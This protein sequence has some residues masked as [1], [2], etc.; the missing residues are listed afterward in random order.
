MAT[1]ISVLESL[2]N[3]FSSREVRAPSVEVALLP[4]VGRLADS[5]ALEN[6]VGESD[7]IVETLAAAPYSVLN[8][9][10][11]S[12]SIL[13]LPE[14]QSPVIS[15]PIQSSSSA[16]QERAYD[17]RLDGGW[18]Q[19]ASATSAL[20]S[21]T[22]A[23]SV[24]SA[25]LQRSQ[26]AHQRSRNFGHLLTLLTDGRFVA[27]AAEQVQTLWLRCNGHAGL[28]GAQAGEDAALSLYC[29]VLLLV[30]YH[31]R[32]AG[33]SD[34][35]SSSLV[36]SE[37]VLASLY[38]VN[39]DMGAELV[40]A[41]AHR[42]AYLRRSVVS[43]TAFC[44]LQAA[45]LPHRVLED[46]LLNLELGS[47][48]QANMAHMAFMA[49]LPTTWSHMTLMW[50]CRVL[51]VVR[52]ATLYDTAADVA[53]CTDS[54]T[55]VCVIKRISAWVHGYA[56]HSFLSVMSEAAWY[57]CTADALLHISRAVSVYGPT[58]T[59]YS[60]SYMNLVSFLHRAL[61]R[62]ELPYAQGESAALRVAAPGAS[63]GTLAGSSRATLRANQRVG[64]HSTQRTE[65][66]VESLMRRAILGAAGAGNDAGFPD[67]QRGEDR[68]TC[69]AFHTSDS[70]SVEG[71]GVLG[72][73]DDSPESFLARCEADPDS[74][75]NFVFYL[76]LLAYVTSALPSLLDSLGEL[77]LFFYLSQSTR[78]TVIA[79]NAAPAGGAE[80]TEAP[81]SASGRSR[82]LFALCMDGLRVTLNSALA[83]TTE[84]KSVQDREKRLLCESATT[85]LCAF[86]CQFPHSLQQLEKEAGA[87]HLVSLANQVVTTILKAP[88]PSLRMKR[89]A[90]R[91]LQR[92]AS[93]VDS[94]GA[95]MAHLLAP[96]HWA[97]LRL[98]DEYVEADWTACLQLY[99]HLCR[100]IYELS[101]AEP[102]RLVS[103]L[104]GIPAGAFSCSSSGAATATTLVHAI[105]T[106]IEDHAED[107][108]LFAGVTVPQLPQVI[109]RIGEAL[110]TLAKAYVKGNWMVGGESTWCSVCAAASLLYKAVLLYDVPA[111]VATSVF[112]APS[113][114][115]GR[116][117]GGSVMSEM[118][119]GGGACRSC[120]VVQVLLQLLCED[121]LAPIHHAVTELLVAA[122]H[123]AA[124]HRT[125]DFV[126]QMFRSHLSPNE[127]VAITQRILQM[128]RVNV[129]SPS[130][131]MRLELVQAMAMWCPAL[132]LFVFGP[133]KRDVGEDADA[134][135]GAADGRFGSG[136][137][138]VDS[139]S[140]DQP[141]T[142]PAGLPLMQLLV[143]TVRSDKAALY[144]KALALNILRCSG[145]TKL[146]P[147]Q[148]IVSLVPR[149]DGDETKTNASRKGGE[150]EEATLVVAC[151]AYVNARV[152]LELSKAK[153]TGST[154]D[155]CAASGAGGEV[156]DSNK[157]TTSTRDSTTAPP[158]QQRRSTLVPLSPFGSTSTSSKVLAPYTDIMDQLLRHGAAALQRVRSLYDVEWCEVDYDD[159]TNW[160]ARQATRLTLGEN[161]DVS[162]SVIFPRGSAVTASKR[163]ACGSQLDS[164]HT[165]LHRTSQVSVLS[166]CAVPTA[167]AAASAARAKR[168]LSNTAT[169][170][171][172]LSSESVEVVAAHRRLFPVGT[173]ATRFFLGTG[174]DRR[175]NSLAAQLDTMADL[176][177]AL[178]Q[179][180]WLS[181]VDTYTAGLF[182][183]RT[184]QLL[185]CAVESVL[186]CQPGPPMLAPFLTRQVQQQLRLAKAATSILESA[187][188]SEAAEL[189]EMSPTGQH[190][191]RRLVSFAKANRRNTFVLLDTLPVVTAFPL[192]NFTTYATMEEL[193]AMVQEALHAKLQLCTWTA[194]TLVMLERL[195][196]GCTRVFSRPRTDG[197]G[198][199]VLVSRLLPTLMQV[200]SRL[201]RF[202]QP[203]QPTNTDA[204]RFVRVLE[205]VGC[206]IAH[207]GEQMAAVGFVEEDVLLGFLQALGQFSASSVYDAAAQRHLRLAW[208][209]C[210]IALLSLWCTIMSVR[211]QYSAIASGWVPS[212]KAALLSSPRFAAALSAFAGVRGADRC[213]LLL[214]EVEEVDWCTR[215]V[216]VLAV[217]N[218]LLEKLT[219]CVQ[220]GFVFLR[221]P[222]LQQQCVSSLPSAEA[223]ISEG[224]RITIAQSYVLRSELTILLKQPSYAV[225]RDGATLASFV[226]PLEL[227]GQTVELASAPSLSNDDVAAA[228]T[229]ISLVYSLDLLRQ[230]TL[231]ELQILRKVAATSAP[232]GGIGLE[233]SSNMGLTSFASR[234]SSVTRSSSKRP[235]AGDTDT[236]TDVDDSFTA[237][238]QIDIATDVQTVHLETVQLA[239]T[240]YAFTVQ[241]FI[242]NAR[243]APRILYTAEVVCGV[244]HSMERLVRTLRSFVKDL[245]E[246]RWPL[247]SRVVQGQTAQLQHFIEC[248]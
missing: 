105:F 6:H 128:Q 80:A 160:L 182:G 161:T 132:F 20:A 153:L 118:R 65:S 79:N 73:S 197:C 3:L 38:A 192:S 176:A 193:M 203:T 165:T 140:V 236:A 148:E 244:R 106:L 55:A 31:A 41:A 45:G 225:P 150:W 125:S 152:A 191:L 68:I 195:V 198:D 36:V 39:R 113:G 69:T 30:A 102:G 59:A 194:E 32:T 218:V 237:D 127:V 67:Q 171:H 183:K 142:Q 122:L 205:C 92:Y 28:A 222:H 43:L 115:Q 247:L 209:V 64:V 129:G 60:E 207:C 158:T 190:S 44:I 126:L 14:L 166:R 124:L 221:Q 169:S 100:T 224:K 110:D 21:L 50:Q 51:E 89:L 101:P 71:D 95:V 85:L 47:A 144:E 175:L 145:M 96:S 111:L 151:V 186:S 215:L 90:Y 5:D 34:K 112:P 185:E 162:A 35:V 104:A 238:G 170:F 201:S 196:N 22:K 211:G 8:D 155:S 82:S 228:S 10:S 136:D 19:Q 72:E 157:S 227:L 91:L 159:Q 177:T 241:D 15:L 99:P 133:E 242:Q 208:S 7:Y 180:L 235:L 163:L 199:A 226:F 119:D 246:V 74:P 141:K 26:R 138:G 33:S 179:L 137:S 189:L 188:G 147:V 16:P 239:L 200:A 181:G 213:R 134:S 11:S 23:L 240:A 231:W 4:R 120:S 156:N 40:R 18:P 25:I 86:L 229:A 12:S 164:V 84:K 230:F 248:L 37:E 143:E 114:L 135:E 57:Y 83:H 139:G 130:N 234:E 24:L 58:W 2:A 233:R 48:A 52:K 17:T 66:S 1:Q 204:L 243:N 93:A 54:A 75:R 149:N 123:A 49:A 70:A 174:D 63:K 117:S 178:E 42:P 13:L 206:V 173:A 146:V 216:A 121:L 62:Y 232:T 167:L 61:S 9:A 168:E 245:S 103:L 98:D 116:I 88:R 87:C 210:W 78:T 56:M 81:H 27:T 187:V 94:L 53:S 220:A 214:W 172:T 97:A 77:R 202:V 212:L 109:A 217:Q 154:L 131:A 107:A 76:S 46:A 29:D 108:T 219:P 223:A 184:Q